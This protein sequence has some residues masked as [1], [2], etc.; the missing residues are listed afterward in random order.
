MKGHG[1]N[2]TVSTRD[3]RC[4][5]DVTGPRSGRL[6]RRAVPANLHLRAL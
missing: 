6:R 1:A 5:L 4:V 3:S 2:F